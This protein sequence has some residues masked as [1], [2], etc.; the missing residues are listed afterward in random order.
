MGTGTLEAPA[1]KTIDF[2]LF[3]EFVPKEGH[4]I[5]F[6]YEAFNFLNDT[7][8]INVNGS[9]SIAT[10][11]GS[12]DLNRYSE[13]KVNPNLRGTSTLPIGQFFGEPSGARAARVIQL[14]ARFSF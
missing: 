8:F 3:K 13:F 1:T 9:T 10:A 12:T 6:R 2:A 7:R 5:Q 4:R 14:G 11:D